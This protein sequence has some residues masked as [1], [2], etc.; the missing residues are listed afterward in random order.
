MVWTCFSVASDA[1][2][3]AE[4]VWA[5]TPG[6]TRL[7]AGAERSGECFSIVDADDMRVAVLRCMRMSVKCSSAMER[8][9]T[10]GGRV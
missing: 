9:S 3:F 4:L 6:I 8:P 1:T 2:L 10:L 5:V 7:W